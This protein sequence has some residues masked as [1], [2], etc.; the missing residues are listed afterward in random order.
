M[1]IK[2]RFIDVHMTFKLQP[3][4]QITQTSRGNVENKKIIKKLTMTT[5]VN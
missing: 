2:K 1:A 3:P 5:N 4:P